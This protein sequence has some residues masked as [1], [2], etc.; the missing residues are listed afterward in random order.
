MSWAD[1]KEKCA[2]PESSSNL[3]IAWGLLFKDTSPFKGLNSTVIFMRGRKG[4]QVLQYHLSQACQ[5]QVTAIVHK[6]AVFSTKRTFPSFLPSLL[7][8]LCTMRHNRASVKYQW[9][10]LRCSVL[11]CEFR[12][13]DTHAICM[14][15]CVS[16]QAR[17][18]LSH[19]FL[20]ALLNAP[21]SSLFFLHSDLVSRWL[22]L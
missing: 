7:V 22:P 5:A 4:E 8:C 11:L 16:M 10:H 9:Q 14:F 21:G 6:M 19:R 20:T 18:N 3:I 2:S 17:V 13:W 12:E 1:K 15:K